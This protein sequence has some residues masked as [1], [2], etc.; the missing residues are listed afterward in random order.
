MSLSSK[1]STIRTTQSTRERLEQAEREL[2]IER[3][4]R[5]EMEAELN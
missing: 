2:Q 3:A 5:E 1:A 4:K